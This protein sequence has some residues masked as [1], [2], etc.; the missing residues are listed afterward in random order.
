MVRVA[1]GLA[2]VWSSLAV[3]QTGP[4]ALPDGSLL[5][6]VEGRLSRDGDRWLLEPETPVR[7][8]PATPDK[9]TA[10]EL[11]PSAVLEALVADAAGRPEGRYR[12][13]GQVETYRGRAYLFATSFVPLAS[14]VTDSNGVASPVPRQG[15][16]PNR[17]PRPVAAGKGDRLAIP[18]QIERRLADYQAARQRSASGRTIPS[19]TL[20]VLL[21][22]VGVIVQDQQRTFFVAD[23][24]GQNA[25]A[26]VFE[27][28]PCG[29]LE[30][31]ERL[32][33]Q[34][35]DP[36][37]FCVSGWLTEYQGRSCLLP[38]RAAREYDYGNFG[39]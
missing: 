19:S 32:Q 18:E 5:R 35:L 36:V 34:V 39:R 12:L 30:S 33:S 1:T 37:R 15:E 24:L 26:R 4:A 9:G 29:T 31:M 16:D 28:L 11:L 3:S 2:A 20:R 25:M 7:Q 23:G 6:G 17:I 13:S 14:S 21:D 22:L 27:V 8:G 10:L 38:H